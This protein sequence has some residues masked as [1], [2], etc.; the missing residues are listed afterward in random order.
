MVHLQARTHPHRPTSHNNP[1]PGPH[2]PSESSSMRSRHAIAPPIQFLSCSFQEHHSLLSP[3]PDNPLEYLQWI[4]SEEVE[5]SHELEKTGNSV[6][7]GTGRAYGVW[8]L[9]LQFQ[10]P[11]KA[12]NPPTAEMMG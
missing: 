10:S 8:S 7:N 5:Q 2:Q 6:E 11:L 1:P 3:S 12:P 9:F 4:P